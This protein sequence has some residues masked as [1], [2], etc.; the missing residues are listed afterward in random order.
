MH[1]SD[2]SYQEPAHYGAHSNGAV[3]GHT[4]LNGVQQRSWEDV[5]V[6]LPFHRHM[7]SCYPR[8]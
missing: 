3:G 4:P 2:L 1:L 6:V 5:Q 7:K 8:L